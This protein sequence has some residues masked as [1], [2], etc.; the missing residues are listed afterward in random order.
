MYYVLYILFVEQYGDDRLLL[1]QGYFNRLQ[2]AARGKNPRVK[3]LLAIGGWTDSGTDAYS[4][5][6]TEDE[7]IE[8]FVERTVQ[9]LKVS[10]SGS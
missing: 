2:S 4:R 10:R 1:S 3:V 6:V 9:F 8:H 7:N 5:L